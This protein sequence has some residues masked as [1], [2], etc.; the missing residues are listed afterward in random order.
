MLRH[1]IG[2]VYLKQW[3]GLGI[4]V[5]TA[6]SLMACHNREADQSNNSS[7]ESQN[8]ELASLQQENSSLKESK[9][10]SASTDSAA[11]S[12]SVTTNS[13]S[14]STSSSQTV[15]G[16]PEIKPDGTVTASDVQGDWILVQRDNDP[17]DTLPVGLTFHSNDVGASY[18]SGPQTT[19]PVDTIRWSSTDKLYYLSGSSNGQFAFNFAEKN[20]SGQKRIL[21]KHVDQGRTGWYMRNIMGE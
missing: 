11:T 6:L 4:T 9:S 18:K 16:D 17:D 7:K 19:M 10:N 13:S 5:M 12:S 2:G 8:S 3:V 21:M 20:V 14:S 15:T 1:K